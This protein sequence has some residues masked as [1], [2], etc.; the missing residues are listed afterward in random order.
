MT[1]KEYVRTYPGDSLAAAVALAVLG[2]IATWGIL[3]QNPVDLVIGGFGF[4][5]SALLVAVV[6]A[7]S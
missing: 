2:G 1:T 5:L 6:M 4:I 7:M 3:S